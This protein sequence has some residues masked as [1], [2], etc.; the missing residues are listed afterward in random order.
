MDGVNLKSGWLNAGRTANS[1]YSSPPIES[2]YKN[3]DFSNGASEGILSSAGSNGG[4]RNANSSKG[5]IGPRP[6]MG[7]MP[8]P[9]VNGSRGGQ[10]P[11][12][13]TGSSWGGQN[14][15][16]SS[17]Q[18]SSH[19]ASKV[20]ATATLP[21]AKTL[22][23]LTKTTAPASGIT[24]SMSS[25]NRSG[26]SSIV[27]PP[28]VVQPVVHVVEVNEESKHS[29]KES[30]DSKQIRKEKLER[31]RKFLEELSRQGTGAKS[32]SEDEAEIP[33]SAE[34]EVA[35]NTQE[36]VKKP[37]EEEITE[38]VVIESK[39]EEISLS[40]E[41]WNAKWKDMYGMFARGSEDSSLLDDVDDNSDNEDGESLLTEE[42]MASFRAIH[43]SRIRRKQPR[44]FLIRRSKPE[45]EVKVPAGDESYSTSDSDVS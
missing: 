34:L 8:W 12:S 20:S 28:P 29:K 6:I 43:G 3:N 18:S 19:S 11:T 44:E 35:I 5:I 17:S 30:D 13:S 25:G 27:K 38:N 41:E 4:S 36:E 7:S 40:K 33:R 10:T 42:E 14:R 22:Q 23:P 15:S 39:V 21:I 31:R 16:L 45:D 32:K 26:G 1:S 24:K 2:I 37:P 9:A